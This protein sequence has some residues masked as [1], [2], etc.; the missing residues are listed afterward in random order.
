MTTETLEYVMSRA[1]LKELLK[2][3]LINE[4]EFKEIDRLNKN[5][6]NK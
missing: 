6:F 2:K 1:L 3:K 5:I 4:E